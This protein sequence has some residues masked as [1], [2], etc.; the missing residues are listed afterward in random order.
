MKF[1]RRVQVMAAVAEISIAVCM[2][3][4]QEGP[5][6]VKVQGKVTLQN[7]PLVA[8]VVTFQPLENGVVSTRRPSIGVI[9]SDGLYR[10]STF[11]SYDGVV[12]GEYL[13]S[14]DGSLKNSG[15]VPQ[16]IDPDAPS[17]Q[18]TGDNV[19]QKY[20]SPQTSG[21]KATVPSDAAEKTIDFALAS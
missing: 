2:G 5:K 6:L 11:S 13:V 9:G 1:P 3:C 17:A 16:S 19:P 12:P 8:G 21:L 15:G 4:G 14:V 18:P 10:M 7:R 20:L